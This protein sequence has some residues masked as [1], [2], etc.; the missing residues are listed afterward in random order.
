MSRIYLFCNYLNCISTVQLSICTISEKCTYETSEAMF[1]MCQKTREKDEALGGTVL[2][3]LSSPCAPAHK[4]S[5]IIFDTNARRRI[6]STR[7]FRS[8]SLWFSNELVSF[9]IKCLYYI[10]RRFMKE[11]FCCIY[12]EYTFKNLDPH[13]QN[14]KLAYRLDWNLQG[15]K[16]EILG[17]IH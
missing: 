15:S 2:L 12:D 13:C 16:Q 9:F 8:V 6:V 5:I 7:Q 17:L 3:S 14:D 11:F 10:Y 4:S 1:S